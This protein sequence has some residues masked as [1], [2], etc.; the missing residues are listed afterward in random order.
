[1]ALAF[2]IHEHS[3]YGP[4]HYDLMLEDGPVLA[5][6]QIPVCPIEIGQ[7]GTISAI[8]LPD[9]R[10]RYL[11]YEGPVSRDRGEVRLVDKGTYKVLARDEGLWR[12]KLCG[13]V[14]QGTFELVKEGEGSWLV[15]RL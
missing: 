10:R 9:H 12:V 7:T 1:M 8:K 3:G 14:L 2:V 15:R 6:W 4:T 11:D 13:G 5:T